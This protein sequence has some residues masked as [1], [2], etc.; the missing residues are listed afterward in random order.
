MGVELRIRAV[1]GKLSNEDRSDTIIF[2][3]SVRISA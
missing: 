2:Y 3:Y 1:C